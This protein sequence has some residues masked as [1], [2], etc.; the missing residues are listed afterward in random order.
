MKTQENTGNVWRIPRINQ[1][2]YP[3]GLTLGSIN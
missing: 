2:I 3:N 1:I